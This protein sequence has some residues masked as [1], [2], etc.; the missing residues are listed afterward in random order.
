MTEYFV[1]CIDDT[2]HNSELQAF[3]LLGAINN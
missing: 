1:S 2:I 3:V